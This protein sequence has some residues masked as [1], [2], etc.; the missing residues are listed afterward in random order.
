MSTPDQPL[1][2]RIETLR[3]SRLLAR[4]WVEGF[5][6]SFR[7]R[8]GAGS[9]PTSSKEILFERGRVA[10]AASDDVQDSIRTHLVHRG[11]LLPEQWRLAQEKSGSGHARQSLVDMGFLTA[12][13]LHDADRERVCAI[14]LGLF[15]WIEGDYAVTPSPLPPGTPNLQIDPRDLVLEGI[16][17]SGDRDRVLEEIGSLDAVL[18]VRPDDLARASLSLPVELVDLMGKADGTRSVADICTMSPLSDFMICAAFAGLKT[19]GLATEAEGGA[20]AAPPAPPRAPSQLR[21]ARRPSRSAGAAYGASTSDPLRPRLPL[22]EEPDEGA[23]AP[24]AP[25]PPRGVPSS[26]MP[27]PAGNTIEEAAAPPPEGIPATEAWG[28][29][30]GPESLLDDPGTRPITATPPGGLRSVGGEHDIEGEVAVQEVGGGAAGDGGARVDGLE[31]PLED[32]E[33]GEDLV[34]EPAETAAAARDDAF[35]DALTSLLSE[36]DIPA[37]VREGEADLSPGI[38]VPPALDGERDAGLEADEIESVVEIFSAP[39]PAAAGEEAEGRPSHVEDPPGSDSDPSDEMDHEMAESPT[40]IYEP[41]GARPVAR[42]LAP[43]VKWAGMAAGLFAVGTI[44]TLFFGAGS[45]EP[46][47]L[48]ASPARKASGPPPVEIPRTSIFAGSDPVPAGSDLEEETAPR[49]QPVAARQQAE[50]ARNAAPSKVAAF[51]PSRESALASPGSGNILQSGLFRDARAHLGA[52]R[53]REAARGFEASL[54]GRTGLY[55]V[56]LALA[57][58]PDT[59]ARAIRS[60]GSAEELFI[61][62]KEFDGR[63]CYRLLWGAYPGR[64]SAESARGSVPAAFRKGRDAPFVAPI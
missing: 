45:A 62:P 36:E 48:P 6:G 12:R 59:V 23:T 31:D 41:S 51:S 8:G 61:L 60:S 14:I 40:W 54:A 20:R 46:G 32:V 34:A 26:G 53:L 19:L 21:P 7:A 64:R 56:Q 28:L 11:I 13:E 63:A 15:H 57:C 5:S 22:G 35:D 27:S 18:V 33:A 43:W 17:A 30:S 39:H 2:G 25:T 58:S 47:P 52:G 44:L 4:F 29:A 1:S 55:T 38:P 37:E 50:P 3:F 10:W 42:G 24:P 9:A 16:M 49:E